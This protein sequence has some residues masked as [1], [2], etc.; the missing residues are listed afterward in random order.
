MRERI[1]AGPPFTT[2]ERREIVAYCRT[3]VEALARLVAHIVPT[4]RSL[5]HALFRAEFMWAAAQQE[6]R[7][8]PLDL[9]LLTRIQ[10]YWDA[11]R[12]DLV[13]AMD[14]PF[15]VYEILD[16]IPH[17]RKER[18]A[19]YVRRHHVPWPTYADGTLD[20][21]A[22]TFKDMARAYQHLEPLREIRAS[23]SKLRLNG[24]QV[25]SDG[26]NRTLLSPFGSKT[27]RNQPSASRYIF[28]P[29]KWIRFLITPPPGIVLVY[30][31]YAQ[32]EVQIAAV[33]SGDTELLAACESGDVYLGIA[34]QLGLAPPDATDQTHGDLRNLF[35]TVVLG[36][37]Y[38]LGPRSLAVRT[39]VSLFE[40]GEILARVR[41]RF[42]RFEDF[43]ACVA[44]HAG[45][46]LALSSSLGW[47]MSSPPEINPRTVRNFPVQ[48]AGADILHAACILAERR[49][50]RIVA[51]VHDAL[52]AEGPAE[53]IEDVSASLDRVMRDAAAVV[54]RGYELRTDQQIVRHGERF[55]DKRGKEMW[56]TVTRLVTKLGGKPCE[57]ERGRERPRRSI[58]DRRHR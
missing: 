44:D 13:I 29:A 16:G 19:A 10:K 56:E 5:R 37:S 43:M 9:A 3:D 20:E 52:M 11:I 54:L 1:I 58:S 12:T 57:R 17:W 28:G 30:R 6:R 48:S 55:I 46:Q 14:R 24:L 18:F 32:Q 4:I 50:L 49:G 15:G 34:K 42:H 36:I 47:R 7:G 25:G 23:M 38:G 51:P 53:A 21:T 31:D 39:G 2:D 35:K 40:A 27:G 8:V 26:R 41:A 22:D 45:L 33:L